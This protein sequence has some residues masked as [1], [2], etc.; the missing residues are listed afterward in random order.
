M[1]KILGVIED[2]LDK[3]GNGTPEE[4]FDANE[5]LKINLKS[6]KDNLAILVGEGNERAK[7]ILDKLEKTNIS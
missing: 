5:E 1:E 3:F 6:F 2:L 7:V 4:K